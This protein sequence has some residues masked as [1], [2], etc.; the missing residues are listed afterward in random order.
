MKRICLILLLASYVFANP[1]DYVNLFT[2]TAGDSGQLYPGACL[3]AGLVKL[4]P[5]MKGGNF[6][7]YEYNSDTL[8]GFAHTRIGGVGCSGA[9][10]NILILPT[11]DGKKE[12]RI[13]KRSETASPGRYEITLESGI[14]ARLTASMRVG[15]HSYSIPE[16]NLGTTILIDAT[17]SR[18]GAREYS[19]SKQSQRL[20]TGHIKG[21]NVCAHGWYTLYFAIMFDCDA[22]D[23]T[24]NDGKASCFFDTIDDREIKVKVALS[25]ISEEQAVRECEDDMRGWDYEAVCANARACWDELLGRVEVSDK[26]PRAEKYKELLYT[27]LYRSLLFPMNVTSSSGEYRLAGNE[28]QIRQAIDTAPDYQHYSGWSSWDDYR[29]FALISLIAPEITGNIARSIAEWFRDGAPCAWADG[30]WPAP[31]VRNEFLNTVLLDAYMKGHRDFDL[32]GAYKNLLGTV[33]GNDQVEKP[34]QAW[35]VMR[36]AEVLGKDEDVKRL[37][38]QALGYEKYWVADQKDGQGNVRGFFTKDGKPVAPESVDRVDAHL[39]QGNLWH[40]RFFVPHNIAGLARL[41]GG[42]ELL[43]EDLEYYFDNDFHMAVNESPLAYPYLFS[44][45]GKPWLTQKWSRHFTTDKV[46]SVYHNHGTFREPIV[47]EIFTSNPE[48]WLPTM[49]DD[50]GAMSSQF[51]LSALGLYP[52][53]VGEPYYI[54]GSPVF[55]DVR[56]NLGGGTFRIKADGNSDANRYVQSARLNGKDFNESYLT[57]QQIAGGGLLELIMGPEPNKDWAKDSIPPSME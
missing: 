29:K 51:V 48:G 45:L 40:Y 55:K 27:C 38:E 24:V 49:D 15:M 9:G 14:T 11:L 42:S 23:M 32:A 31:S 20:L 6:A 3:P 33:Q 41:R 34:Y 1:S 46:R 4:S 26:G 21:K 19:L 13:N 37:R 57:Y 5:E 52:A 47:R 50:A 43:A 7:G 22:F 39:Y 18:E 36:F 56:L 44:Y 30:Y 25:P 12:Q 8:L 17:R 35:V 2:G 28:D 54:I 53:C 10:G 16:G